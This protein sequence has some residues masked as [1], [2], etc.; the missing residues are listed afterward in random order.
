MTVKKKMATLKV[1]RLIKMPIYEYICP[2]CNTKFEK[3][4]SL[5]DADKKCECPRCHAEASRKLSV[6]SAFSSSTS[7]IPKAVP[8]SSGSSCSGCS[9]GNCSSCGS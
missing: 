2:E 5:N 8:G 1:R 9:G 6:F 7:G 4:R 3:L